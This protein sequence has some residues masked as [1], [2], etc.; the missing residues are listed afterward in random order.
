MRRVTHRLQHLSAVY[1]VLCILLTPMALADGGRRLPLRNF[2]RRLITHA[3]DWI[4]IP[5]GV[6]IVK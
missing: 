2:I 5:P 3:M 6:I 4:S 1:L